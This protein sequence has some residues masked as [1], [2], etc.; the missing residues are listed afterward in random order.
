MKNI[1]PAKKQNSLQD[2]LICEEE[3]DRGIHLLNYFICV[4]CEKDIVQSETEDRG[5]KL[6]LDRLRKVKDTLISMKEDKVH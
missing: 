6:Y 4:E 2:C 3:K 5:Y 1:M